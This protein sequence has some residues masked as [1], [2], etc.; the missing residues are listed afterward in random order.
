MISHILAI[1]V[2]TTVSAGENNYTYI[3]DYEDRMTCE[4]NKVVFINHF[5][6]FADN[7]QVRCLIHS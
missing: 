5:G 1:V 6:P 4:I 2:I 7:E 3:K